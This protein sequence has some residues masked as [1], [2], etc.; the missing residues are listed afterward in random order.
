MSSSNED[1]VIGVVCRYRPAAYVRHFFSSPAQ[2]RGSH[3]CH[4][5]SDAAISILHTV[6]ITSPACSLLQ[7]YSLCRPESDGYLS[8]P[9]CAK[10]LPLMSLSFFLLYQISLN[11]ET[12]GEESHGTSNSQPPSVEHQSTYLDILAPKYSPIDIVQQY[13]SWRH[14]HKWIE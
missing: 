9:P 3:I 6:T 5:L 13:G 11:T 14:S 4:R 8:F 2:A 1:V 7:V 12:R 10:T